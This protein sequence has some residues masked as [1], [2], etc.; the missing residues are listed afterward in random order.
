MEQNLINIIWFSSEKFVVRLTNN[1][2]KK[3]NKER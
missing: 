1:K 3:T 2:V